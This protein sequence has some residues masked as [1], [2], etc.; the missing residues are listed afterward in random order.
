MKCLVVLERVEQSTLSNA[1]VFQ[2]PVEKVTQ[3]L[4]TTQA[5]RELA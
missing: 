5:E 2:V 3:K 4:E 1:Y